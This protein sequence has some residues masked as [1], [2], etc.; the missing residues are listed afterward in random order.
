MQIDN[1]IYSLMTCL[2]YAKYIPNTWFVFKD[3]SHIASNERFSMRDAVYYCCLSTSI[4]E[5]DSIVTAV[6]EI[7]GRRVCT[8]ILFASG[9][10]SGARFIE[11]ENV[12]LDTH[13]AHVA[14]ILTLEES[15]DF[16]L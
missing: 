12:L 1:S 5:K 11:F 6:T 7:G 10:F 13:A 8:D 4:G 3:N 2:R 15:D 14:S 16:Q 9:E